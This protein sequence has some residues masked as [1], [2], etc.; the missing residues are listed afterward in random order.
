VR[1]ESHV[2]LRRDVGVFAQVVLLL[3]KEARQEDFLARLKGIAR[4]L[5]AVLSAP[6]GRRRFRMLVQYLLRMNRQNSE[7]VVKR[8]MAALPESRSEVLSAAEQLEARGF[9]KGRAKGRAEGRAQAR[10]LVRRQLER[11]FGPLPPRALARL[12]AADGATLE[13]YADRLLTAPTL[14]DVLDS[15]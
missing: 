8:V 15:P 1:A 14:A 3:L 9:V 13:T 12:A 6:G 2:L 11:R 5:K 7:G 10:S 4:R